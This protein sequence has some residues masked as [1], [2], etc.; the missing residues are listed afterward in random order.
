MAKKEESAAAAPPAAP[1]GPVV[2]DVQ[3]RD[4]FAAVIEVLDGAPTNRIL[5]LAGKI[6]L[7]KMLLGEI[8]S[9]RIPLG[10]S[11]PAPATP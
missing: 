2:T 9:G 5:Q 7:G 4:A 3:A 10:S 6:N 11:P 8:V 1:T